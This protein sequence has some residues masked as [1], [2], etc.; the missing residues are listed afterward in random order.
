MSEVTN[1]CHLEGGLWNI[2]EADAVSED[3]I[4]HLLKKPFKWDQD[5]NVSVHLSP[6]LSVFSSN[7]IS[8]ILIMFLHSWLPKTD[9]SGHNLNK[10]TVMINGIHLE[11]SKWHK[12]ALRSTKRPYFLLRL[13]VN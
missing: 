8:F 7:A 12:K 9:H 1:P 3:K 11:K 2:I 4:K 10:R 6:F 13:L 5:E